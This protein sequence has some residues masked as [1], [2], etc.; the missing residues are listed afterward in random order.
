MPKIYFN[1]LSVA[2]Y[3]TGQY[4]DTLEVIDGGFIENFVCNSLMAQG[5]LKFYHTVSDAEVDFILKKDAEL[6][7]IEVKFRNKIKNLPV[8]M[9]NFTEKYQQQTKRQIL[10]TKNELGKKKDVYKIPYYLIDLI[11]I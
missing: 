5:N 7:P 10:I 6:I 9:L 8:A 3:F 1:N 4:L 11:T 2:N